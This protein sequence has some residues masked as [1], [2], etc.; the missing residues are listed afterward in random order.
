MSDEF[1][2]IFSGGFEERETFTGSVGFWI[3]ANGVL[4][5]TDG[6]DTRR[7]APHA[8]REVRG[9]GTQS[10]SGGSGARAHVF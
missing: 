2:V 1:T 4:V 5:I 3:E 6:D 10:N 7:F 8:W 9:G